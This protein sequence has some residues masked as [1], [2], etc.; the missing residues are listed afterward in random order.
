MNET[1][2]KRVGAASVAMWWTALISWLWL[3]ASWLIWLTLLNAQPR[4]V[5]ILWG[6]EEYI[7]WDRAYSLVMSAMMVMKMLLFGL[8]LTAFFLGVWARRLR[9]A[10]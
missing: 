7:S 10:G 2:S 4:W 9:K 8:I 3:M 5:M 6:G 1:L